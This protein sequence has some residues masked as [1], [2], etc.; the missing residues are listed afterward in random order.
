MMQSKSNHFIK[1][2]VLMGFLF[3]GALVAIVYVSQIQ[4]PIIQTTVNQARTHLFP[5]G[6]AFPGTGKS[7]YLA[8]NIY[9]HS[10]DPA[11]DYDTNLSNATA[12]E[13]YDV[14]TGEMTHTTPYSTA[15]D[16]IVKYR[17]NASDG[18][19]T[20]SSAWTLNWSYVKMAC[21]FNWTADIASS[22]MTDVKISN[23]ADYIY[24]NAYLNN[25]GAGYTISKNEKFSWNTS[26][27]VLR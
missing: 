10:A 14:N 27:W 12:Y 19:N 21:N 2:G 17:L 20:S 26:G 4:G 16:F 6:D 1:A 5:L 15:F 24:I 11:N 23:G 18:Y 22:T 7:G 25:A 8:F 3:I 13:H 9:P